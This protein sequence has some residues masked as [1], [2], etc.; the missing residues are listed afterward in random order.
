MAM[1]KGVTN[2]P[3]SMAGAAGKT[4]SSPNKYGTG[5]GIGVMGGKHTIMT[6]GDKSVTASRGGGLSD[7]LGGKVK[8]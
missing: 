4:G 2:A 1:S 3:K 8:E 6:S 5:S 7:V